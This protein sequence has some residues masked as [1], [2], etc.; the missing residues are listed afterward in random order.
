MTERMTGRLAGFVPVIR[1]F[2]TRAPLTTVLVV[3]L[4]AVGAATGS[5]VSGPAE[6]L[7]AR[8]GAGVGPLLDDDRWWTPLSAMAWSADL[9]TYLVTTLVL[10]A[11][12]APAERRLGWLRVG[13]ALVV[14][15]VLAT[16]LVVGVVSAAADIGDPWAQQLSDERLLGPSPGVI[17]AFLAATASMTALWRRRSRLFVLLTLLMLAAYAGH[18]VDLTR[19]AAGLL[20]FAAGPLFGGRVTPHAPRAPSRPEARLLVALIVATAA[21]GPVVAAVARTN[22]GPLSVLQYVFL[23][24]VP[25]AAT[26]HQI[27]TDPATAD[28]CRALQAQLQLS[29]LGPAIL[30]V[31]PVILLL[32]AAEGLR[33]GRRAA[34]V[35][36]VVVNLAL[37]ALGAVFV[38]IVAATPAEDLVVFGGLTGGRYRLALVLPLLVPLGTAALL[39]LTRKQFAVAGPAGVYHRLGR[40]VAITGSAVSALYV[41]GGWL[42]RDQFDPSPAIVT[43]LADLPTRFVPPGYLSELDRPFVPVGMAATVLFEWTGAAFWLVIAA[44]LLVSF[45]HSAP[46]GTDDARG[47]AVDLLTSY[48]GSNLS[49]QATWRGNDYWLHPDGRAAVAYRLVGPVAITVGDPF[50]HPDDRADC[51]HAFVEHCH[52][53]GWIP[54]FYSITEDTRSACEKMGWRTVQVAT[55]TILPLAGLSFTG[56]RWQDVRTAL[57]K[58]ARAGIRAEWCRFRHAPLAI[59]DQIRAISEEWVADKGM[60][61]MGFTLGGIDELADDRVRC[62]IAVDQDRTVHGITSWL[63]VYRNG[64]VVGWT[65]DYMRRRS[66]ESDG[67][68]GVMEF[69]IA[70]AALAIRDEGGEF[71]SLSGAPLARLD[72]GAPA[73]RLQRLLDLTGSLLEPVYGFT[74]LFAFKAKF[75]PCYQPLYLAYP[76]PTALPAIAAAIGRAYLPHLNPRQAARLARRLALRGRE[77]PPGRGSPPPEPRES[78]VSAQNGLV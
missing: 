46:S 34:W 38:A 17:C 19:L 1:R 8:I 69:L 55:E 66:A 6:G 9:P 75:Q 37:T 65:L 73:D 39:L 7:L 56:K 76:D 30:S 68:K 71:L 64:H 5:L 54:C 53:H 20:G 18:L 13:G 2:V 62:L 25:D 36:A 70:S 74:S 60:P 35:T 10:L 72:R 47:R 41:A 15:Q 50:G 51:P 28:D 33:R 29:G 12:L 42:L 23:S 63:P 3:M 59:T 78:T 52:H 58:A 14:G 24:P 48:G 57:N 49:Y 22:I 40:T 44:T 45:L 27:C 16:V 61:E 32:V 31:V 77:R 67:F 4:W 11:L 21:I 43:L 26:V